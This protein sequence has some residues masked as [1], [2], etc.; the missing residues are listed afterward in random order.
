MLPFMVTPDKRPPKRAEPLGEGNANVIVL[1]QHAR[2]RQVLEEKLQSYRARFKAQR[3]WDI[4]CKLAVLE[5][6]LKHGRV[7]LDALRG[8][9]CSRYKEVLPEVFNGAAEAIR[10]YNDTLAETASQEVVEPEVETYEG[11]AG[12]DLSSFQPRKHAPVSSGKGNW[13][14]KL[15]RGIRGK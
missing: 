8:K 1:T 14:T 6:L 3:S 11:L 10:S 9:M 15:W 7:D 13:L 12:I 4:A 5:N 2:V